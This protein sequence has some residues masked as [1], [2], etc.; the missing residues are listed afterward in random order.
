MPKKTRSKYKQKHNLTKKGGKGNWIKGIANVL[1]LRTPSNK[2]AEDNDDTT[3][4]VDDDVFYNDDNNFVNQTLE[5]NWKNFEGGKEKVFIRK[6]NRSKK[7]TDKVL[8]KKF[9]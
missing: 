6:N 5:N 9:S 2:P 1:K 8:R 3:N 7:R 4:D